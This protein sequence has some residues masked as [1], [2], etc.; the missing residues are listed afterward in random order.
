MSVEQ[1]WISYSSIGQHR[2]CPQRWQYNYVQKLESTKEDSKVYLHFGMWWHALR[3][4]DSLQRGRDHGSLRWRPSTITAVSEEVVFSPRDRDYTVD[5]V[6]VEATRWW[7]GLSMDAKEEWVNTLGE[8]LPERLL[9]VD[10]G[11]R[12]EHEQELKNEHPLAVEF[13]WNRE[14]TPTTMLL[15]YIDEVYLDTKR[16]LVVVRDHK[17][18]KTL[19]TQT[20]LDDMMDSQLQLYAWGASLEVSSWEMG[21]IQ[22]VAYDRVRSLKPKTPRITQTGTLSKS[23]TDFDLRTYTTWA[24]GEDGLGQ[25]F[26]GRRKDQSDGG[27]YA[28]EQS[29]IEQL[30]DPA[31]RSVW[32]QRTLTPLNRTLITT[33]LKAAKYTAEAMDAT[34]LQVQ[35]TGEGGRNLSAGCRWCD[36]A[37]LCRA[38][39]LGGSDGEYELADHNLRKRD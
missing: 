18:T 33:H 8:S 27:R 11:W 15:G 23:V 14:L 20:T 2:G 37:S 12:A 17:T 5:D 16:N 19:G 10:Q 21:K 32:Y 6:F 35:E 34:E 22:A 28:I 9:Y 30:S 7:N 13:R 38:Q 1:R 29:V 4:I 3:A 25:K 24:Q 31:A 36:F 39:M 26:T